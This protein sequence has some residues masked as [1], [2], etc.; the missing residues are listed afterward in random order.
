MRRDPLLDHPVG[1]SQEITRGQ[2]RNTAPRIHREQ[3]ACI[4]AHNHVCSSG[5]GQRQIL[6]VLWIAALP[7]R[8]VRLDSVG[9]EYHDVEDVLTTLD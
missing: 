5:R 7:D 1:A 9:R 6:V 8:F 3:M 2:D 4:A